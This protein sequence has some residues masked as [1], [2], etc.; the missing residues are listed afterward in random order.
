VENGIG[1]F[2]FQQDPKRIFKEG[3]DKRETTNGR[4]NQVGL[5]K[6]EL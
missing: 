1:S 3:N 2:G 4:F 6:S 5:W